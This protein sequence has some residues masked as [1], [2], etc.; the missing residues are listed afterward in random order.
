MNFFKHLFGRKDT[1]PGLPSPQSPPA[2]C[3]VTGTPPVRL[4]NVGD[5][6]KLV[7]M[8][9]E[10][11][12]RDKDYYEGTVVDLSDTATHVVL[13]NVLLVQ[14]IGTIECGERK[15]VP[16]DRTTLPIADITF[17]EVKD[18]KGKQF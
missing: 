8:R 17:A 3:A 9:V 7:G 5:Y 12:L 6:L 4:H 18:R 11:T 2:P 10:F 13:S 15:T 16:S 1:S 14:Y